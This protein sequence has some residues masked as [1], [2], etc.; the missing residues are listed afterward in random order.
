MKA[1][2]TMTVVVDMPVQDLRYAVAWTGAHAG[3]KH[4][5]TNANVIAIFATR[6]HAEKFQQKEWPHAGA[7]VDVKLVGLSDVTVEVV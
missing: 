1:R 2:A 6:G 3:E 4:D 5:F 7:V